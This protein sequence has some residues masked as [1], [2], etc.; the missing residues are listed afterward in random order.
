MPQ[1][2]TAGVGS[3][4]SKLEEGYPMKFRMSL[5]AAPTLA[6]GTGLAHAQ[7]GHMMNGGGWYGGWM[8]G[9]GG[10][11]IPILLVVVVALLVWIVMQRRK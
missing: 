1:C 3:D 5:A 6:M 10:M 2:Q 8:G 11:W 4:A 9:Y 7:G